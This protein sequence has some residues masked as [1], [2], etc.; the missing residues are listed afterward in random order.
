MNL[1]QMKNFI[2]LARCLNF[3]EAARRLYITQ[4]SLSKKISAIE[5]EMEIKL[6]ERNNKKTT[7]TSAGERVLEGFEQI[8]YDYDRMLRDARQLGR[9]DSGGLR[10]AVLD[11][12][13]TSDGLFDVIEGFGSRYP[14]LPIEVTVLGF[15]AL[16]QGLIN[17]DIDIGVTTDFEVIS[18]SGIEFKVFCELE[19]YLA[20]PASHPNAEKENPSLRDFCDMQ[21]LSLDDLESPSLTLLLRDSCRKAGVQMSIK[22]FSQ[23][24]DMLV[25]LEVGQGVFGVNSKSHIISSP[26]LKFVKVPEIRNGNMVVA[27]NVKNRNI[28]IPRFIELIE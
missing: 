14:G 10:I 7:L 18:L 22:T 26:G 5:E 27:W 28:S 19:N 12:Q 2:T 17:G 21:L 24:R 3:T 23:Y 13:S 9:S 15:R 4:P 11:M 8:L 20:V 6:L 16:R 25:A 1:S